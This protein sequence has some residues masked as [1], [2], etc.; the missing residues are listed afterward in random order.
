MSNPSNRR[1][2]RRPATSRRSRWRLLAPLLICGWFAAPVSAFAANTLAYPGTAPCDTTLQACIDASAAGDTIELAF[3]DLNHETLTVTDKSITL[4]AASG[5]TPKLGSLLVVADKT[6][7][8]FTVK[9]LAGIGQMAA[10]CGNADLN[11]SVRDNVIGGGLMGLRIYDNYALTNAGQRTIDIVGNHFSIDGEGPDNAISITG[12]TSPFVANVVDNDIHFISPATSAGIAVYTGSNPAGGMGNRVVIDRN[13]ITGADYNA[14]I[15]LYAYGGNDG[16]APTVLLDAGVTNNLVSGQGGNSGISGGI[17]VYSSGFNTTINARIVNNTIV[18]GRTGISVGGRGDRNGIGNITLRNNIVAWNSRYG[19]GVDPD[20]LFASAYNLVFGNG[21]GEGEAVPGAIEA[22]P[23][24][25][26]RAAKDYR[27]ASDSPAIDAGL[28]AALSPMFTLDAAG[29]PRRVGRIDIG[30]YEAHPGGAATATTLVISHRTVEVNQPVTATVTVSSRLP[31]LAPTAES[32]FAP[33]VVTGTVNV[34]SSGG[35]S[36]VAT[37]TN[38][39]GSCELSHA[40]PGT[41]AITATYSGDA[42]N[43]PSSASASLVVDA[44]PAPGPD[45]TV[46]APVSSSWMLGLLTALLVAAGVRGA[47]GG[48]R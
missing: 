47:R 1:A 35:A 20:L 36:C 10:F 31:T 13:R 32:S 5:R 14:G 21:L 19:I 29:S 9:S 28:D 42:Q 48:V 27:L 6:A 17:A 26:D 30:A 41:H 25:V 18:D 45:T 33:V 38:G 24:F 39:I 22:D 3:D 16:M 40:T 4:Q 8:A 46:P 23:R 37:L 11:L 7:V 12:S 43:A 34:S 2:T 44:V 15:A